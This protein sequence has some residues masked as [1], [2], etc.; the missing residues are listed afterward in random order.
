MVGACRGTTAGDRGS[1]LRDGQDFCSSQVARGYL[2]LSIVILSLG[3][4]TL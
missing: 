4:E 2:L 3:T 1:S